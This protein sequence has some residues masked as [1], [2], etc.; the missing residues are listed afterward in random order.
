MYKNYS[1]L[2]SYNNKNYRLDLDGLRGFAVILVFFF[3][4]DLINSGFIGVDIFFTLSGYLITLKIQKIKK[5]KDF[6]IFIVKRFKR[7]CPSIFV[8]ASI[9]LMVA[10]IILPNQTV[11]WTKSFISI[12]LNYYNFFLFF[13]STDYFNDL[14]TFNFFTHFWTLSVEIQFYIC[15]GII[16]IFLN[17]YF[18]AKNKKYFLLIIFFLSLFLSFDLSEIGRYYYFTPV[19][20]FEFL[21]GS[22][23]AIITQKDYKLK[24]IELNEVYSIIALILILFSIFFLDK[25]SEYPFVYALF[26]CFSVFLLIKSSYD[27]KSTKNY[28][29]NGFFSHNVLSKLG[30]ISYSVY[31]VHYPVIFFLKLYVKSKF[32]LVT[33]SIILTLIF[34]LLLFKFVENRFR[35]AKW[36]CFFYKYII[37]FLFLFP[38]FLIINFNFKYINN[39]GKILFQQVKKE[40]ENRPSLEQE[41]KKKNIIID[42]NEDENLFKNNRS[43][44]ILIIGD[45]HADNI[46]MMFY[47]TYKFKD[48]AIKKIQVD[49][50]CTNIKKS[51]RIIGYIIYGPYHKGTCKQQIENLLSF[52]KK[53]KVELYILSNYYNSQTILYFQDYIYKY[54]IGKNVVIIPQVVEFNNFEKNILLNNKKN[55]NDSINKDISSES[56]NIKKNMIIFAKKNNFKYFDINNYLCSSIS[57]CKIYNNIK[58]QFFFVDGAGH[59]SLSG[60]LKIKPNFFKFLNLAVKQN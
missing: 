28:S 9:S 27:C 56:I 41:Y 18:L 44:T 19:R 48:Y 38:L 29:I 26:P 30:K 60:A 6:F 21:I 23:A 8:V 17:K 33:F 35:Y 11:F 7:L 14:S 10:F 25:N 42:T 53:N 54:F 43:K 58:N 49:T 3:H 15:T 50:V 20:Y 2:S 57:T 13:N 31:L 36:N 52:M 37:S 47:N 45:S 16:F 51:Q 59:L 55:V 22:F 5:K 32:T 12:F 1:I 39:N 40:M 24:K 34:A 4:L 46:L